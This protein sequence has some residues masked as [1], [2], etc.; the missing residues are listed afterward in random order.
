MTTAVSNP[1][2]S[3]I[4]V[5]VQAARLFA[6]PATVVPILFATMYSL[7]HN[8]GTIYWELLPVVIIAGILFHLGTNII[9]EYFDYIKGV[10]RKETFG[11]S[12][13]LVDELMKPKSTLY[14]GLAC[15]IVG[16]ALG[17]ILVYYHGT[18]MLILGIIG[19]IGSM[20]YTG[21]PF[22]FKYIA[23]GDLNV[24]AFFGPLLVIGAHFSLTG[25]IDYKLLYISIPIGFLVTAILNANNIRDIKHDRNAK[26]KTMS[27][28]M[29]FEA[30]RLEYYFLVIGAFIAVIL[31]VVF[32]AL[33]YWTLLVLLSFKPALDNIKTM[34]K[35][36]ADDVTP[37]MM[38]DA[39]TAQHH[40]MFGVLYSIG[41]ML[42][43][44]F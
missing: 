30:S 3:A 6:L 23:L 5:W 1:E 15:Y 11:S 27:T 40:L 17:L 16:F 24:F 41:M 2:R 43:F 33:P 14:G 7:T 19:L 21:K 34:S 35:A 4:S 31:M 12:R 36:N 22:G 8:N 42:S 10:D 29:G 38:S 44:W 9:G 20:F 25:L 37:I 39:T 13:V 18:D 28:M 26:I 32:S